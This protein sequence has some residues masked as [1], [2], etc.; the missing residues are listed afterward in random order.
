ME[1]KKGLHTLPW[2]LVSMSCLS[3]AVLAENMLN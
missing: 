3:V 2:L 1:M